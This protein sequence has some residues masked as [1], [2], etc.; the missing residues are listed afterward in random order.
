MNKIK[1]EE[2]H[3]KVQAAAASQQK[4]LN[5]WLPN[6]RIIIVLCNTY[7]LVNNI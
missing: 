2:R 6:K 1:K 4:D 5:A 3:T 7:L